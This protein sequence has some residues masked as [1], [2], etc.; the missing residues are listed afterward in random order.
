MEDVGSAQLFG[1]YSARG[2]VG[3]CSPI[4]FELLDLRGG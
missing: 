1:L 3:I 2:G 4:I